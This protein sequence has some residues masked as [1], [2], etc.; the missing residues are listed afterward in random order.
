MTEIGWATKTW[1][2]IVGCSVVSPGCTNCY[3]M[4]WAHARLDG[5][6]KV[7][8]YE[9][10]T[11]K[12]NGKPVW[13][14]V[15]R[16]AP[17]KRL[18]HPETWK[19]PQNVFVNSMGDL[20]HP[21][22]SDVQIDRVFAMMYWTYKHRYMVLT[23][24][25]ERMQN[26]INTAGRLWKIIGQVRSYIDNEYREGSRLDEEYEAENWP[27]ENVM[28]GTS[29]EDQKRYNER[30]PFLARTPAAAR[31]I[32]FE[33]L[34]KPVVADADMKHI[35]WAIFGCEKGP[36]R[37]PIS[38]DDMQ[39]SVAAAAKHGPAIFIKQLDIAGRVT[40]DPLCFPQGLKMQTV[41]PFLHQGLK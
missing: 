32:S 40:T 38:I 9:G 33:P 16:D 11:R 24:H 28:L 30:V 1:N 21:S 17:M 22:V 36:G 41:P 39:A 18:R 29:V 26:Y 2:P 31:F 34:L 20:F 10:T 13:T 15:I 4:R 7:P 6:P 27:L 25:P 37:R 12:V 5:N 35:N 19:T 23:K 8:H 3:A 14:G